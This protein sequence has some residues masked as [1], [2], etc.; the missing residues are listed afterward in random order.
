MKAITLLIALFFFS[1]YADA[2]KQNFDDFSKDFVSGYD[3][4]KLAQL[5]PGYVA[6]FQHIGSDSSIQKQLNFFN[7]IKKSLPG[8]NIQALTDSQKTDYALIKYETRLNLQ[9]LALEEQWNSHKPDTINANGIYTVP[10]G[11]AW[12]TYYLNRWVSDDVT[13][14]QIF[15]MGLVEIKRVQGKIEAIRRKT[16]L[17]EAAF[18][19]HLNDSLFFMKDTADILRS[20]Q[21]TKA[22][23]YSNLH[24]L[25]NDTGIPALKIKQGTLK[26]MVQTPGYYDDNT[27]YYNFFNK[28]YNKRQVNW[29]FLHEAVPGHHYQTS[30]IAKTKVSPVQQLF[31]YYGF[32]EGWGAYSEEL[33]KQLGV[34]KTPYDELGKW[35][36][37]IVRSV[38]VPMD[39]GLN[40]YG[41]TDQQALAFWKKNIRGQDD[42]AMREITRLRRWP[43][44]CITY[45]YGALQLL[46]WKAE[47][48]KQQGNKFDIK[49]FHSRVLDHGSLPI[50]MVKENV[51][52][53]QL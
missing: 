18:Q 10:D 11:K 38:R 14:D 6:N 28:P 21:N 17:S 23:V 50:F 1:F 42:I 3:S 2:Q 29:L 13:P 30:I 19:I 22:I 43:A 7:S 26:A 31:F 33:G 39:V 47:L 20:F 40:Y 32:A 44:Q 35:E 37:D 52:N 51:F 12:Y 24:N 46:H 53:G 48:Q 34:Y 8:F 49:N 36:W 4:L 45:K 41:W 27:F 16:G 15:Q 5:D 9:R 25:F